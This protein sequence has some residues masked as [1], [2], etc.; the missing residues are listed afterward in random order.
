MCS[1]DSV[2]T[3]SYTTASWG[4]DPHF[5]I[6]LRDNSLLC[7]S[8]QGESNSVFNLISNT[9]FLINAKFTPDSK[10]EGVTWM[11]SIGVVIHKTVQYGGSRVTHLQFDAL[12]RTVY[13]GDKIIL[14]VNAVKELVSENGSLYTVERGHPAVFLHHP[15]VMVHLKDV[16]LHF[17]IK[18][19]GQHLDMS[20][21]SSVR[22]SN[23]HGLI[24]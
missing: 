8:V 11:G 14:D 7:Y 1:M 9:N 13:I 16:G 23:S 4:G 12:D 17:S 21:H 15:S 22:D 24:G 2:Q 3:I 20:W 18:F 5:S 6:L 19:E 10:R